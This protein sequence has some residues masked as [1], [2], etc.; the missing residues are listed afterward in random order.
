MHAKEKKNRCRWANSNTPRDRMWFC[1]ETSRREKRRVFV[2]QCCGNWFIDGQSRGDQVE[3]RFVLLDLL[4]FFANE[5]G[6]HRYCSGAPEYLCVFFFSLEKRVPVIHHV[7]AFEHI[8]RVKVQINIY[9][10]R[11]SCQLS[12]R[13][14]GLVI[15]N[16]GPPC[17]SS[18]IFDHNRWLCRSKTM[19]AI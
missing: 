8:V 7:L 18:T 3:N 16:S 1:F 2:V 15:Q 11:E 17:V 10:S 9:V 12:A 13:L 5:L 4:W 6:M 14:P 19:E